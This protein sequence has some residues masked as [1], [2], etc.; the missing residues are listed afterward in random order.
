V[1][2]D[3]KVEFEGIGDFSKTLHFI[4]SSGVLKRRKEDWESIVARL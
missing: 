1:R 3:M 2:E 4:A